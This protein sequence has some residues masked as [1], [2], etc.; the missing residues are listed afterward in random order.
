MTHRYLVLP[1]PGDVAAFD[2]RIAWIRSHMGGVQAAAI[3]IDTGV[4]HLVTVG[5]HDLGRGAL[6][7]IGGA[8]VATVGRHSAVEWFDAATGAS[9]RKTEGALCG[10]SSRAS[11]VVVRTSVDGGTRSIVEVN[12][13]SERTLYVAKHEGSDLDVV[14]GLECV[15]MIQGK[16]LVGIPLSAGGMPIEIAVPRN[17]SLV[18]WRGEVLVVEDLVTRNGIRARLHAIDGR[19]LRELAIVDGEVDASSSVATHD[20]LLA[21]LRDESA[22]CACVVVDLTSGAEVVRIDAPG[23]ESAVSNDIGAISQPGA[24]TIVARRDGALCIQRIALPPVAEGATHNLN[25]SLSGVASL[26]VGARSILASLEGRLFIIDVGELPWRDAD[27][28]FVPVMLPRVTDPL[29][30]KVVFA[31][32]ELVA[33]DH[34]R[35]GRLTVK[36]AAS[37]PPLSKGD[38]IVLDELRET[39]PGKFTV[40][41]WHKQGQPA[42]TTDLSLLFSRASDL[43]RIAWERPAFEPDARLPALRAAAKVIDFAI[44]PVLEKLLAFH[45]GELGFR[46]LLERI[47]ILIQV[48]GG[49]TTGSGSDPCMLGF[50]G[51]GGGDVVA[52]YYYP[53]AHTPGAELPI[54]EWMHDDNTVEW[55]AQSFEVYL[56]SR[57]RDAE[58]WANPVVQAIRA[59]LDLPARAPKKAKAPDWFLAAHGKKRKGSVE[60]DVAHER[61]LVRALRDVPDD[62]AAKSELLAL[63]ERL[64]WRWHAEQ[65]RAA[66]D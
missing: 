54:V 10:V 41:S 37:T 53:P 56:A 60:G 30:A 33:T 65:L 4:T 32:T 66:E 2:D 1:F 31:G 38:L 15:W 51:N 27:L 64:G 29:P 20:L 61:R 9:M 52:L 8:I 59:R 47:S 63:Y 48:T 13:T 34:P 22:S 17:T 11:L 7:P 16:R 50:A 21:S 18:A 25:N 58:E 5:A 49:T 57:L 14:L 35:L 19:D 36:R 39:A 23:L 40:V 28:Q 45:D 62:A 6:A 24:I 46:R 12:G 44:P 43:A 55:V 26:A 42:S 3:D